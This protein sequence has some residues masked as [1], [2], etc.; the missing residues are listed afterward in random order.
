MISLS[1]IVWSEKYE[2]LQKNIDKIVQFTKCDEKRNKSKNSI[3]K[4]IKYM[5]GRVKKWQFNTELIL[6]Q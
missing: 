5:I 6:Q 2:L 3:S 4:I 1:K